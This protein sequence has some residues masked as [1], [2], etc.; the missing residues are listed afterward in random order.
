MIFLAGASVLF[1]QQLPRSFLLPGPAAIVPG[2]KALALV[3][4][5]YE[6]ECFKYRALALVAMTSKVA[7][8]LPPSLL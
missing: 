5:Q 2:A 1:T 7:P 6:V 8:S 3:N 4:S